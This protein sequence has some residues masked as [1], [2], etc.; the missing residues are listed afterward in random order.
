[1]KF[2]NS[3]SLTDHIFYVIPTQ[4]CTIVRFFIIEILLPVSIE[5][6]IQ[7]ATIPW[8]L[9]YYTAY[10][11]E[12]WV[13]IFLTLCASLQMYV[14]IMGY[15]AHLHHALWAGQCR[16]LPNAQAKWEKLPKQ[17]FQ[18]NHCLWQCITPCLIV[19][20]FVHIRTSIT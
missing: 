3:H 13:S 16:T 5:K 6:T 18:C 19:S 7:A 15:T 1:M 10:Q 9:N 20:A 8:A 12:N 2:M 4:L 17:N 14:W 11:S